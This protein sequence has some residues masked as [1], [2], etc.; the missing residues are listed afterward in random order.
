MDRIL[1]LRHLTGGHDRALGG[2]HP[3]HLQAPP[4]G[5]TRGYALIG[6]VQRLFEHLDSKP[7]QYTEKDISPYLWHNGKY[8]ASEECQQLRDGIFI[9]CRLRVSGLFANPVSLSLQDLRALDHHEQITQHFCIRGWS[10]VAKWG[11][12]SMGTLLDLVCPDS[13]AKWV[14]FYSFAEGS[15]GGIYDDAQ[16]IELVRYQLTM[17]AYDMNDKEL[18]Y[19]HG[20]PLRLRNEV[21]LGFKLM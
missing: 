6:P 17:L 8:P 20:A 10:G 15:D 1:D 11:W 14:I 18:S 2:R 5:P 19:G 7:G 21:Q 4:R 13:A 3:V 16:P 9:G 12:L